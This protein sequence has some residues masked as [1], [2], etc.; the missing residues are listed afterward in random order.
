V[1][2]Q[3]ADE[4]T[5]DQEIADD[6]AQQGDDLAHQ[7]IEQI[8]KIADG[9][10]ELLLKLLE[11]ALAAGAR[12]QVLARELRLDTAREMRERGVPMRQISEAAGVGDSYLARIL[13]KAG[14]S[15]RVDR[16]RPRRRRR[17]PPE[18]WT[19]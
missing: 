12:F 13:I 19:A 17:R 3:C 6:I 8:V 18:E 5:P 10:V 14:S 9:D 7:Y 2:Q 16:T 15:R 11:A 4:A 1:R